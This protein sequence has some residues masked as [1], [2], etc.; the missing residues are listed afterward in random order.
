MKA[1]HEVHHQGRRRPHLLDCQGYRKDQQPEHRVRPI[2]I[3]PHF[4]TPAGNSGK[5]AAPCCTSMRR[6]GPYHA[7]ASN[8]RARRAASWATRPVYDPTVSV[9]EQETN[10][11]L[12]IAAKIKQHLQNIGAS[13]ASP[14]RQAAD[15]CIKQLMDMALVTDQGKWPDAMRPILMAEL[16][17]P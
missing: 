10:L 15:A 9:N 2:Q 5:L 4:Y 6:N 16:N 13:M 7:L 1:L 12:L 17:I 8:C 11:P 3:L 14:R